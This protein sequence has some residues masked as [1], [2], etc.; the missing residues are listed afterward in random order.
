VKLLQSCEQHCAESKHTA[1]FGEQLPMP[2]TPPEH[3][4][5]QHCEASWQIKPSG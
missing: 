2:Q 4:P 3:A 5:E 1:P